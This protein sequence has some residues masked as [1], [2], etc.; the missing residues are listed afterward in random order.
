MTTAA[1]SVFE[2]TLQ[3]TDQWLNEVQQQMGTDDPHHAYRA[4][5]AVLMALRDRI[6]PE[7]ATDLGA[8]L[9][10]LIRGLYYDQW[11]PSKTPT[12]ERSRES[13]LDHIDELLQDDPRIDPETATR[14]VFSVLDRHVTAGEV[15]HVKE[16]L[17]KELRVLWP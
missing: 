10:M 6:T 1:R 16:M 8:Q 14:A 9:P 5:H 2:N 11:N 13:F 3:K 7:E 4:L 15:R 17:P 12:R